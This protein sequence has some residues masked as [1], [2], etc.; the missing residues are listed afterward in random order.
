MLLEK[1]GVSLARFSSLDDVDW[2]MAAEAD[3]LQ[4]TQFVPGGMYH[5]E[6]MIWRGDLTDL[7]QPEEMIKSKRERKSVGKAQE[8]FRDQLLQVKV[9]RM[10]EGLFHE[11][12]SLYEDTTM[13]RE[14]P[15]RFDLDSL[16]LG[17]MRVGQTV[18]LIGLF[19]G[20]KLISG[21]LFSVFGNKVSVSFGAKRKFPVRGGVGGLFEYELVR[22]CL[23]HGYTD[24][25]HGTSLNPS[26]LYT[27]AG[28]FE[29]KARY[30]YSAHPMGR[31]C[32]TFIKNTSVALS[33]FVFVGMYEGRETY[34]VVASGDAKDALQKYA[35][36][37]VSSVVVL[38]QQQVEKDFNKLLKNRK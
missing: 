27:Q 30:G 7:N 36:Q 35:T 19:D 26:G 18:H 37:E 14:R 3:L 22:F 2:S 24:I 15:L 4:V 31:W 29:F 38:T 23:E 6:H 5:S 32:S 17:K 8:Y 9:V 34:T 25:T 28:V 11:F 10:T 12:K 21:L 33:D 13:V 16:V 1:N 20:K